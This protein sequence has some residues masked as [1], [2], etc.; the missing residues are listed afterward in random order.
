MVCHSV[1]WSDR[2]PAIVQ[3]RDS[4]EHALHQLAEEGPGSVNP[5][6]GVPAESLYFV[7]SGPYP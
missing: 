2:F 6:P 5:G 3:L 1:T 4:I 7:S